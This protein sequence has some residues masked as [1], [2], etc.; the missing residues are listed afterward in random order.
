MGNAVGVENTDASDFN[1]FT[2]IRNKPAEN[3][4]LRLFSKYETELRRRWKRL[5]FDRKHRPSSFYAI[6]SPF[7]LS[8]LFGGI[9]K[10]E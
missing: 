5:K 3:T 1:M 7:L 6:A 4:S 10:E 8:I 9:C 2:F